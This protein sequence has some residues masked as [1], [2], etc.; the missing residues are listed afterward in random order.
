MLDTSKGAAG[1]ECELHAYEHVAD[2]LR[3]E[4]SA[5]VWRPGVALPR[6]TEL[7]ERFGV[8]KTT[9]RGALDEL[10]RWGLIYTGYADGRK[11]TIVRSQGRIAHYATDAL[12]AIRDREPVQSNMDAFTSNAARM[13]RA[14]SKSFRM[15]IEPAPTWVVDRLGIAEDEL[16]VVRQLTQLLD[17]EPWSIETGYYPR[18]LASEVGLDTPYDIEQGTIRAL[19]E[20]GYIESGHRDELTYEY[21]TASTAYD[22]GIA[23]GSPIALQIR[24]ACTPERITRVMSCHRLAERSRIIWEIGNGPAI[25]ERE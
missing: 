11:S 6:I 4:I 9:V 22:L 24:V 23:V 7:T 21:A 19:A 13:G 12:R 5:G 8:S 16:V 18:K 1:G 10:H 14:A 20:A 15:R 17:G 2:R 25:E 3:E